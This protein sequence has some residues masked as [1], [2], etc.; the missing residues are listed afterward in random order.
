VLYAGELAGRGVISIVSF[1]QPNLRTTYEPVDPVVAVG[2]TVVAGE[3]IGE[4]A[5][6]AD[7]CGPPGSCLHWGAIRGSAYVDPMGLLMTT[8]IRLLPIW[9]GAPAWAV[10]PQW[11]W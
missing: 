4:V 2:E 8:R 3:V 10:E 11:P 5:D 6:V 9:P 1:A 7:D